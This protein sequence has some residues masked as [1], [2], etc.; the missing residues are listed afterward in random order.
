MTMN[1]EF[2]FGDRLK[3]LRLEHGFTQEKLARQLEITTRNY[4]YWELGRNYPNFSFLRK[5]AVVFN[6]SADYLLGLINEPLPIERN[7]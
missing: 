5:L 1:T 7:Q 3:S 2:I 6:V 4:Q